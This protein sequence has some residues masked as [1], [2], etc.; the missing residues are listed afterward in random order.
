[1]IKSEKLYLVHIIEATKRIDSYL[2]ATLEEYKKNLMAQDAVIKVLA[3]I[4]ESA[5]KL[6]E[7]SKVAYSNVPWH[8]IRGMRNILIH[9]YLGDIEHEKIWQTLKKT[10]QNWFTQHVRY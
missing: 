9:E 6:E 2:P 4:T 7:S 1:M 5:T 3:N 8:M 10:C